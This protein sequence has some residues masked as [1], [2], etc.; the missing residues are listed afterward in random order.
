MSPP[1]HAHASQPQ[2]VEHDT[3]WDGT[4][5]TPDFPTIFKGNKSRDTPNTMLSRCSPLFIDIDPDDT[6]PSSHFTG[7]GIYHWADRF[8]RAAPICIKLH[9]HRHR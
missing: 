4:D 2:H 1:F 6:G 9:K 8:T 5:F 7:Q 3:L